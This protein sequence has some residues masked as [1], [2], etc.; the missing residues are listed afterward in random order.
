LALGAT[1]VRR[2]PARRV[3]LDA[4]LLGPPL[5]VLEI[6][7]RK[8]RYSGRLPDPLPPGLLGVFERQLH[9][10]SEL[11]QRELGLEWTPYPRVL[12]DSAAWFAA[13]HR[14][15]GACAPQPLPSS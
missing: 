12:N 6:A 11:A 2:L 1:P 3:K 13:A 15:G 8:M 9:L 7:A 4:K 14:P 10:R 5:K